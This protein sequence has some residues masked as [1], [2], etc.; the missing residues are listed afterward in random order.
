VSDRSAV[1]KLRR[2]FDA[3]FARPH[4]RDAVSF[5]E[6]LLIRASDRPLALHAGELRGIVEC[7]PVTPVPSGA[8][9]CLGVTSVRGVLVGVYSLAA[10][11]D[12]ARGGSHRWLAIAG[13][14]TLGF[15]FDEL[16]RY[17]RVAL[18]AIRRFPDSRPD[19]FARDVIEIAGESRAV[20]EL[21]AL[22]RTI[23]EPRAPKTEQES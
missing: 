16:E 9:G 19:A 23:A 2:E 11:V 20:V 22:V 10:L 4:E 18:D 13:D 17:E 21:A 3:A 12:D 7:P 14:G 5:A 8:R 1:E 6:L 15:A